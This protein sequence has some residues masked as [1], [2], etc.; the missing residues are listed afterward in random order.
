MARP[1]RIEFPGA[2]YHVTSRGNARQTIFSDDVDRAAFLRTL[3]AVSA[4]H[5]WRCHA[6]CLMDNHYHLVVETRQA[7]LSAGMRDL[8][9][10]VAQTYN[11]RHG[12]S[13]HLFQGRFH[14]V[15][16]EK[17]GHLL[18]LARYV[19]LN[20]CRAGLCGRPEKWRW[21]SYRATAGLEPCPP[22]V[23]TDWLL[24]QFGS[25]ADVA[26]SR[27]RSFVAERTVRNPWRALKGQLYLGSEEFAESKRPE[28]ESPEVPRPQREPVRPPLDE[29]I[30]QDPDRGILLAYRD[31]GY[32]LREVAEHMGVHYSTVGRRLRELETT[33]TEP[34]SGGEISAG[35]PQCKT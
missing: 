34:S 32:R 29:I 25:P 4:R 35:M 9:G 26:R 1:L 11:R 24:S 23:T 10:V 15:L 18:E 28:R 12:R 14:A 2:L 7:T 31:F 30:G 20:P 5:G 16:V 8:N 6:Y 21:S 22:F 17:E 3:E 13:G 19:V 33:A 27:Y